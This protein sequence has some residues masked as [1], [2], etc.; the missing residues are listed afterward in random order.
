M[1]G[2][3]Q[4]VLYGGEEFGVAVGSDAD[5]DHRVHCRLAQAGDCARAA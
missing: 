1:S 2:A 5:E 4:A 3:P